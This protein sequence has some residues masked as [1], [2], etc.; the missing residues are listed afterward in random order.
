MCISGAE[1][2]LTCNNEQCGCRKTFKSLSTLR[3]HFQD[4]F[5]TEKMC[6]IC[7]CTL[8]NERILRRHLR[9]KHDYYHDQFPHYCSLC[10]SG[11]NLESTFKAHQDLHAAAPSQTHCVFCPSSFETVMDLTYHTES[12]HPTE[13]KNFTCTVCSETFNTLVILELHSKK[14]EGTML[15]CSKCDLS[16]ARNTFL[17]KHEQIHLPKSERPTYQCSHCPA[18]FL[19]THRR[20]EHEKK[21]HLNI[22]PKTFA[23]DSCD[24]VYKAR[25]LWQ[26]HVQAVHTGKSR[27]KC[28]ACGKSFPHKSYLYQHTNGHCKSIKN[29][30]QE[31]NEAKVLD[32]PE[33]FLLESNNSKP[34]EQD[35]QGIVSD[36]RQVG[37]HTT[38]IELPAWTC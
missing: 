7:A 37:F 19:F 22:P 33:K 38:T 10:G 30:K 20:K 23:C 34:E 15:K 18:T 13:R 32:A 4:L 28:T 5:G 12:S 3:T 9:S 14:H 29:N 6:H 26:R 11:F 1:Q 31:E 35:T 2:S 17:R 27:V 24:K 21:V 25:Y 16:F 8:R 36:F